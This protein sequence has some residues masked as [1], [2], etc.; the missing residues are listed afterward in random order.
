MRARPQSPPRARDSPPMRAALASPRAARPATTIVRALST[1]PR[2]PRVADGETLDVLGASKLRVVQSKVGY[3]TG[4]DALALAW[5]ARRSRGDVVSSDRACDLGAG[6][7]GAVGLAY[8]LSGARPARATFVEAQRDSCERLRRSVET[9]ARASDAFDVVLGDVVKDARA[10][11]DDRGMRRAFD[12]VLLNPPFFDVGSGTPPKN[13][14]K[15][16]ARFES[17]ATIRDFVG[18]AKEALR[19]DGEI[20]VVYPSLGRARL[21]AAMV[22]AFGDDA[23]RATDV[24]DHEGAPRPSLVFARAALRGYS[25]DAVETCA[26]YQEARV[27]EG[28]RA[29]VDSFEMFL[30]RVA[31]AGTR[32]M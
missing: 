28:K 32:R 13:K 27:A 31:Q 20:F 5:F 25:G 29:Y 1:A 6:S 19:E 12:V 2:A 21:L 3:R 9:N 10:L 8:A 7:S 18:F 22:A 17:T 16:D 24:F 26:L 30:Q 14:E 23:V 15:K 4:V 11:L